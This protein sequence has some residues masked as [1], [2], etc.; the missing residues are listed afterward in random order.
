MPN[1]FSTKSITVFN[2]DMTELS[3]VRSGK[4]RILLSKNKAKVICTSPF[5]IRLNYVKKNK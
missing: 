3:P 5:V 4:A 2:G 1:I